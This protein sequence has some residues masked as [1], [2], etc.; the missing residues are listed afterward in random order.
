MYTHVQDN[1]KHSHTNYDSVTNLISPKTHVNTYTL[2]KETTILDN[3]K[4]EIELKLKLHES[5]NRTNYI[6]NQKINKEKNY[7]SDI[8]NFYYKNF[9]YKINNSFYKKKETHTILI[10]N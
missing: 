8:N 7:Y 4:E 10:S 6:N 5:R 3:K 2:S 1:I 9:Y